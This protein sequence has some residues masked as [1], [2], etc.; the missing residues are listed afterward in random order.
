MNRPVILCGLGRVGWRVFEYLRTAG[1]AVVVIDNVCPPDDP[2]L[3]GARLVTGD[4]QQRDVLERA[5]VRDCRG[6]LVLTSDDLVNVSTALMVRHLNADVRVVVRMFNQNLLPRLGKAVANVFALSTSALTAPLLALTALTGNALGTF[7]LGAGR[8]QVAEVTVGEHSSLRGQTV[9]AA[10]GSH[11][12]QVVAHLTATGDDRLLLD[13]DPSARLHR[14]D[15]LV[16]CGEPRRV[17]PLLQEVGAEPLANLRWAGWVRRQWRVFGRTLAEVD[18]PVKI[19]TAILLGVVLA[20]TLIYYLG[21][22]KPLPAGL[23]RT[24]SVMAT[25]ADMHEEELIEDWEKVFVSLLR[26]SGAALMGAFTAIITNYLLRA[27]LS[28]ALDVGRIPDG[29]HVVVC[30]LGNVGFQVVKELLNAGERVA[31]I[32]QARDSR[33]FTTARRLGVAVIAGDATVPDVLRQAHTPTAR[34]VVIATSNEL[35]NLEIALLVRELNPR[36]R[37]VMRLSNPQ[38]AQTLREEANIKLALSIPV[39][40]APAFVAA[41]FGER[42]PSVF[43]VKGRMLAAAELAVQPDD[44]VLAGQTVRALSFDYHFLPLQMT[45]TEGKTFE[46]PLGQRLGAGDRLTAIAA[47][48]DLERLMR[49]EKVAAEYAVD[50]TGYTRPARPL[51]AELLRTHRGLDG[52]AADAALQ[53]QLP[54]CLGERWT[55]GQAEEVLES[56]RHEGVKAQLRHNGAG[57]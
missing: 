30:G 8:R 38:L 49:R 42:V 20:S 51:V 11:G 39:L 18:L 37:V 35:A 28:G 2:R 31:V 26:V 1:V 19:C 12:V 53:Q 55:R 50:V 7:P 47:L 4:C 15:R 52:A 45:T 27:K 33:F 5:G 23:F 6:V 46:P 24:I 3:G 36:Q 48:S 13:V 41:L 57:G 56:L 16:V 29:G 10:A 17:A 21:V 32:E 44:P 34:A 9:A 40:A 43:L 25:G 54:L 14:G 22:G